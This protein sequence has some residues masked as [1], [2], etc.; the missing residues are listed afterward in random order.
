MSNG[1]LVTDKTTLWYEVRATFLQW[2]KLRIVYNVVLVAL[3]CIAT[4]GLKPELA[5]DPGFW[6]AAVAAGLAANVCF[7]IGPMAECYIRW[8][9]YR[10]PV[11]TYGLFGAGMAFSSAVTLV[12][13]MFV[14][15]TTL[16]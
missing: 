4:F 12:A 14:H 13:A 15:P 7:F 9:G 1:E 2:E 5:M 3:T 8:L 11:L 6:L 10:S 16:F